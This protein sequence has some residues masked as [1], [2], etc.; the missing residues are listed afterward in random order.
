[1]IDKQK[2]INPA[3]KYRPAPFWSWN[4]ELVPERLQEQIRSMHEQGLGGYYMH[5]RPGMKTEYLGENFKKAV[6]ACIDQGTKLGMYTNLYD[7]DCYPSGNAAGMVTKAHPEY[8]SRYIVLMKGGDYTAPDG[9]N[10]RFEE[11]TSAPSLRWGFPE[12]DMMSKDAMAYFIQITHEWYK[13]RFGQ[14]FG[15]D[16]SNAIPS[17]FADEP[18]IKGR[19]MYVVDEDAVAAIPWSSCFEKEFEE[20]KGYSI[21]DVLPGMFFDIPGYEKTRYDFFDVATHLFREAYTIQHFEWCAKNN[22][23][24]TCHF[25]EHT[26]PD[27]SSYGDV[28]AHYEFLQIPGIDML[29]NMPDELEHEQFGFD[30]IVKEASSAAVQTGKKRVM[31]ETHGGPGWDLSFKDQKRMLDWQ[32]ALGINYI[33]PHLYHLSLEGYR[34][35]DWPLSFI[36]EPWWG[37]YR[38]LADYMSRLCYL[39]S[40]GKFVA[41]TMVLHNYSSTYVAFTPLVPRNDNKRLFDLGAETRD[42]VVALSAGQIYYD[43][44]SEIL[45]DRHGKVENGEICIG[46]M[47]YKHLV[48]PPAITIRPETMAMIAEFKKQGGFIVCTGRKPSMIDGVESKELVDLL[49][50]VPSVAINDVAKVLREKGAAGLRLTAIGSEAP[51]RNVYVHERDIDGKQLLFL[52]NISRNDTAEFTMQVNGHLTE[53]DCVTGEIVERA[54][55]NIHVKLHPCGS[56]CYMVDKATPALESSTPAVRDKILASYTN[57][58]VSRGQDNMLTLNDCVVT[59]QGDTMRGVPAAVDT[60]IRTKLFNEESFHSRPQPW[61][62]SEEEKARNFPITACY[63]FTVQ[64]DVT[65]LKLAAEFPDDFTVSLNGVKLTRDGYFIDRDIICYPAAHALKQGEN[66]V[67]LTGNYHRNTSVESVYVMGDFT[68]ECAGDKRIL[69]SDAMPGLGDATKQGHQFYCGILS[70]EAEIDAA[71]F[72]RVGRLLVRLDG[73]HG[74][75]AKVYVNEKPV[76]V[77]GWDPYEADITDFICSETNTLRVDLYSSGQN[78]FGP[79]CKLN[80]PGL[81]APASY[82]EPDAGVFSS[83]GLYQGV[84]LIQRA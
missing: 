28:M 2:F 4:H 71:C 5:P 29:F 47:A 60:K 81:A 33:V 3:A 39:L 65:R 35:R 82:H 10:Y 22:I 13:E 6:Q 31:S 27:T 77:V 42:T 56:V 25:W 73:F 30:L 43:L 63:T 49:A 26:Y 76:A 68:V 1:M 8:A 58:K 24:F 44:G 84:S 41:D 48:I 37:E 18:G 57:F 59:F 61:M 12:P 16:F 19:L 79:F 34:K 70:Y 78:V 46:G 74:A 54:G 66:V 62:Y 21:K 15:A 75:V 83:F 14:H 53:Y 55:E 32:F 50:D 40:E 45:L 67:E 20:R 9:K 36:H 23:D 17:V 38:I 69:K 80:M 51:M 64:G 72:D 11:R 52:C 7:E